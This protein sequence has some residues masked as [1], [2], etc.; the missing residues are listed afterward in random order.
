[1]V[2]AGTQQVVGLTTLV[3]QGEY[4]QFSESFYL[5]TLTD[6][7]WDDDLDLILSSFDGYWAYM[8]AADTF[9]VPSP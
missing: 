7:H 4:N 8:E 6:A 5:A 1:Y 3:S 9:E 2:T